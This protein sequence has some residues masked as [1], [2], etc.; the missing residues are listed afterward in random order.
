MTLLE[1]VIAAE[2]AWI[3][4]WLARGVLTG[5][6]PVGSYS[7]FPWWRAAP[8]LFLFFIGVVLAFRL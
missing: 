3:G 8:Y 7:G 4:Y 2:L 6:E 1:V 5:T